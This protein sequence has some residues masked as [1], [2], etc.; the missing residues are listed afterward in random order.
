MCG[1]RGINI[2]TPFGQFQ[3]MWLQFQRNSSWTGWWLWTLQIHGRISIF[4]LS[5]KAV[6]R[7]C[8]L[9]FFFRFFCCSC[10]CSCS[11]SFCSFFAVYFFNA[12]FY[13]LCHR[14][15]KLRV[16]Q[17]LIRLSLPRSCF[18][19]AGFNFVSKWQSHIHKHRGGG[20]RRGECAG[21]QKK[22]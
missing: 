5:N 9:L 17:L 19:C 3:R 18:A 12:M 15:R 1:I 10:S 16:R 22:E 7:W 8:S 14:H 11:C 2:K 4:W 21:E 6:D 13:V 20:V